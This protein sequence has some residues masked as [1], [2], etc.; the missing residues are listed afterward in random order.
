MTKNIHCGDY[1]V[2]LKE[3][4]TPHRL[5]KQIVEAIEQVIQMLQHQLQ[6]FYTLC[7]YIYLYFSISVI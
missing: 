3:S 2:H 4:E 6:S 1:L 7:M 5:Y